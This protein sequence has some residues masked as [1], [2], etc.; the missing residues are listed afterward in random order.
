MLADKTHNCNMFRFISGIFFHNAP[1]DVDY[2]FNIRAQIGSADGSN[3]E[4]FEAMFI[5]SSYGQNSPLKTQLNSASNLQRAYEWCRVADKSCSIVTFTSYD[6]VPSNWAVSEYY[7][8]LQ[9]GACSDSISPPVES[10]YVL[11]IHVF[12]CNC[13]E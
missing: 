11:L 2:M 3:R 7:Y 1:F 12:T 6:I 4:P 10:W 13:V 8:Q 5:A 9:T